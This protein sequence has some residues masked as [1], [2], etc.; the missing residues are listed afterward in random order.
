MSY[1][2]DLMADYGDKILE[3]EIAGGKTPVFVRTIDPAESLP[4][5]DRPEG[6]TPLDFIRAVLLRS[7]CDADGKRVFGDDDLP[8][9]E[10]LGLQILIASGNAAMD[11]NGL[12]SSLEESRK[13][14][15]APSPDVSSS[16]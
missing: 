13:K 7:L 3:V 16:S 5:L 10:R 14:S 6:E 1:Q 2:D 15:E 12:S 8:L 9:V 4:L 11:L